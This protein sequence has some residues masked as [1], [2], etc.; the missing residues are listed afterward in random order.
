MTTLT[1]RISQMPT[2]FTS[3]QSTDNTVNIEKNSA[4]SAALNLIYQIFEIN[5]SSGF[6]AESILYY[7]DSLDNKNDQKIDLSE[8]KIFA[9]NIQFK[10]E[11]KD[12]FSR[13]LEK[14]RQKHLGEKIYYNDEYRKRMKDQ[15]LT[16]EGAL[17][18]KDNFDLEHVAI[19]E[20]Q[21]IIEQL[22]N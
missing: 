14:E 7:F 5:D 15:T 12:K 19:T 4:H 13:F 6:V 18:L 11:A 20:Y 10:G 16:K 1:T 8:L 2:Q 21:I 22:N 9:E 17:F 3:L